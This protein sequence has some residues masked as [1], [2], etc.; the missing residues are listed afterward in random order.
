MLGMAQDAASRT[1]VET[2]IAQLELDEAA[3][4]AQ[5]LPTSHEQS[6]YDCRIL[7]L[8]YLVSEAP[9]H[10]ESF[11][12][13][14]KSTLQ[15]LSRLPDTNPEKQVMMAELYFIRGAGKMLHKRMV[16]AAL[17]VKNA[18]SLLDQNQSAFPDN[19][20]QKKL[21]GVYHVAMGSIPKK[22]RWLSSAVCF[23]GD[24]DTGLAYLE[25]AA[26]SSRLMGMEAE[27]ILFYCE[28]NL[29]SEPEA[30]LARAT[31]LTE[32]YPGSKILAYLKLSGLLELRRIDAAL[33]FCAEMEPLFAAQ[34]KSADLPIWDYT[35]AK[36]HYFRLDFA[37]A[38]RYFDRFLDRYPGKTLQADAMF[39]KGM[40][41]SLQDDYPAA[42]R[43]FHAMMNL[44]SSSFDEDEYARHMAS[45]YRF[46]E[47][48]PVEK[49]LFRARNLFD[50]GFYTRSVGE[51][52]AVQAEGGLGDNEQ[53]ELYYR[54]GR[55]HQALGDLGAAK[56]DYLNCVQL[57]PGRALWMKVYAHFYLGQV[58]EAEG[59]LAEAREQYE[60]ALA[61]YDYEYQ[62]GLE[63]RAKAS[64]HRLRKQK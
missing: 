34:T 12:P 58:Y 64:L 15:L 2:A 1:E 29:L 32:R 57:E 62:S 60:T 40:A 35:R 16:G 45:I 44:E 52:E 51:L 61:Y 20:E 9:T 11:L 30:A 31:Q 50:G 25:E 14:C 56:Q 17:D 7:F 63:Q 36:A 46:R 41:L 42:R 59:G 37:E 43:V 28:K 18:C 5:R 10:W 27:V 23:R 47:P 39:R 19:V 6:Y 38:E 8:R 22:L 3:A 24:L 4:L 33:D 48:N 13:A 54:L 53:T 49:T 21:L 55:N 26:R